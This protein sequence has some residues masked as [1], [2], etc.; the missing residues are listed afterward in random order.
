M[1]PSSSDSSRLAICDRRYRSRKDAIQPLPKMIDAVGARCRVISVA[2][3]L[4]LLTRT[5]RE[6]LK[7]KENKSQHDATW[8]G[9]AFRPDPWYAWR[10]R[11]S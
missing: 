5:N 10:Y 8:K 7:T 3:M 2:S 6:P 11:L 9:P 1:L 4:R